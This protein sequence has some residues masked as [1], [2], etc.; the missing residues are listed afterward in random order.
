MIGL[1]KIPRG[2]GTDLLITLVLESEAGT[3]KKV[4][5]YLMENTPYF[6]S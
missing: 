1:G 4:S 2:T 6:C 3:I 5:S